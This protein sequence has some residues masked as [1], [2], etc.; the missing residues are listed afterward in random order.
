VIQKNNNQEQPAGQK[1][2]PISL[3]RPI[4]TGLQVVTWG[5]AIL[6]VLIVVFLV[7]NGTQDIALASNTTETEQQSPVELAANNPQP[8]SNAPTSAALPGF[9]ASADLAIIPR[10]TNAHTIIPDRSRE[11]PIEYTVEKLD[12]FFSIAKKFNITPETVLWANYEQFKDS[13]D[14]VPPGVKLIIPATNGVLYKW[15]ENDTVQ[16]VAN[17]FKA[18]TED[19]LA[20]PPNKLDMTN[21]Q[22]KA[23]E[24]VMIPGGIR[25]IRQWVVPTIPRG[26]AGVNKTVLGAGACDT[27]E[28]GAGG[29]GSFAWPA[30]NHHLSGNDYWSGHLGVDIAALEGDPI[31]AADSGVVVYAGWING[32]YGYMVMIDHANGYQTLYAHLSQVG[33]SC[34][35]SVGKGSRIGGAGNTGNSFGAHLHFEVRYQGGFINPWNILP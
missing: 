3:P 1:G 4:E 30:A 32:G 11:Q 16:D 12:S 6:M 8:E 18:K 29:S 13:P 31:Y 34:G 25:E 21:P 24:F 23:G 9:N 26:K 2:A 17:R 27:A 10:E 19:I 15:A 5:L 14:N 33:V 22:V 7:L 35:Q 20:W 28:G